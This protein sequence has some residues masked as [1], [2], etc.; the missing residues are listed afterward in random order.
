MKIDSY[1]ASSQFA[2]YFL[3]MTF[4]II[5]LNF[6]LNWWS[7]LTIGHVVT[8]KFSFFILV[9]EFSFES[10]FILIFCWLSLQIFTTMIS[11]KEYFSQLRGISSS[12]F[13]FSTVCSNPLKIC[14]STSFKTYWL[15]KNK[16]TII[17]EL[18]LANFG[19]FVLWLILY[20]V[21]IPISLLL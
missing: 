19:L 10:F 12:T 13:Y 5:F 11:L 20:I 18:Y 21:N 9:N 6:T 17:K 2:Q 14:F 16:D 7:I 8:F 15:R 3:L 1:L 4:V